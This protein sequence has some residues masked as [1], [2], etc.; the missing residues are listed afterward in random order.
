MVSR[1][2]PDPV[3]PILSS[4]EPLSSRSLGPILSPSVTFS[5]EI[6][7]PPGNSIAH[8]GIVLVNDYSVLLLKSS[9]KWE[10]SLK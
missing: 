1:A 2:S 8:C 5:L 4:V 6:L 9:H 7:L 3:K 10:S